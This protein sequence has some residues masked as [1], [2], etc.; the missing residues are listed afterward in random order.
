MCIHYDNGDEYHYMLIL[1]VSTLQY[2]PKYGTIKNPN[3]LKE[4]GY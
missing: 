4:K 2:V 1:Y 3:V